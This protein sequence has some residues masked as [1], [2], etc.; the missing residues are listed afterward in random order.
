MQRLI[1][2]NR[3]IL[4]LGLIFIPWEI[5]FLIVLAALLKMF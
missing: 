5:P 4:I 2:K 3:S 1:A